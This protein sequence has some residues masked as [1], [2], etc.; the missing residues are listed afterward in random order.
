MNKKGRGTI[1][2]DPFGVSEADDAFFKAWNAMDVALEADFLRVGPYVVMH[3]WERPLMQKCAELMS[4]HNSDLLEI[5]FGMGIS[6]TSF[7]EAGPRKHTIIEPHPEIYKTAIYWAD[8]FS[9]DIRIIKGTWQDCVEDLGTFDAVY[10]DPCHAP[11]RQELDR[12]IFIRYAARRLLRDKGRLALWFRNK[13]LP[14][15]FQQ[16]LLEHF[17]TVFL[18]QVD[19]GPPPVRLQQRG[20]RDKVVIPVA[21]K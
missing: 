17:S 9:T 13:Y 20:Y 11:S 18:T 4:V 5:G 16:V 2:E 10:F 12:V 19:C 14:Y 15:P 21:I 8:S 7:Q 3:E 6:A 1:E